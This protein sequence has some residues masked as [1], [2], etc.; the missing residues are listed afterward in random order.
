MLELVIPGTECFDEAKSEFIYGEDVILRLEHS[1]Y[2]I[3]MWES[4]WKKPFLGAREKDQKTVAEFEDYVKCMTLN[5]TPVDPIVYKS[6]RRED[7]EKIQ[8][9]MQDSMTATWFR[10]DPN[11]RPSREI[12]TAELVYYWMI[13]LEIPFECQ[14]WHFNRLMTLIRV[15]SIKNQPSKKQ[16]QADT[17]KQYRAA[18]L[19]RRKPKF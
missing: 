8:A 17:L 4:K 11:Q 12:V 3:A 6:L 10:E 9:Y 15:A 19:A 18:N 2:A 14:Y 7:Y 13:A 5:E 1:L 16:S